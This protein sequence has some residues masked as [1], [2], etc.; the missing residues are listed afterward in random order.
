[1]VARHHGVRHAGGVERGHVLRRALPLHVG[2]G[3]ADDVP[4]MGHERQIQVGTGGRPST[5][6]AAA[7]V[8][9]SAAVLT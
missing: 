5:A 2:R 3:E 8:G 1:M 7:M 6:S 9:L 4:E